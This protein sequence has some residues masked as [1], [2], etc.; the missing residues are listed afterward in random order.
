MGV[1]ATDD[2]GRQVSVSELQRQV[3][4]LVSEAKD[5]PVTVTRDGRPVAVMISI[6]EYRRLNELEEQ[7]EDLYWTALAMRRDLEWRASGC[8]TVPLGEIETRLRG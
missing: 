5:R 4:R 6:D 2:D 3:S 8:P 1:I 7:V